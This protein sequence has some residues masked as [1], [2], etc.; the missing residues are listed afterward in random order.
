VSQSHARRLRVP[1]GISG[2]G[3]VRGACL[4]HRGGQRGGVRTVPGRQGA[5]AHGMACQWRVFEARCAVARLYSIQ[6]R[7]SYGH[8]VHHPA[9]VRGALLASMVGWGSGTGHGAIVRAQRR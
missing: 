7:L 4:G 3:R 5:V 2:G 6:R 8:F 1:I 9:A